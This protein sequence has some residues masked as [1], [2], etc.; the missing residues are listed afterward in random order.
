MSIYIFLDDGIDPL[1]MNVTENTKFYEVIIKYSQM[2]GKNCKE[3]RFEYNSKEIDRNNLK[4][5]KELGILNGAQIKVFSSV[6]NPNNIPNLNNLNNVEYLNV[7]FQY[8]SKTHPIQANYDMKFSE[9]V[10]KFY[11]KAQIK[12]QQQFSFIFGGKKIPEDESS[13]LRD[14]KFHDQSSV[15]VLLFKSIQGAI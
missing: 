11:S 7:N 8:E 9:L 5:I 13:T 12:E 10:A 1:Q 3:L 15:E 2:K 4:T 6:K 14:L